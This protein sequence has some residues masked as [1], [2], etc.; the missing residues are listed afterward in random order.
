MELGEGLV[1]ISSKGI[2]S[3]PGSSMVNL[4]CGSME[5][6][7]TWSWLTWS[8]LV[9]MV[10]AEILELITYTT[11]GTGMLVKRGLTSNE[12]KVSSSG[13]IERC[14]IFL[15]K[16]VLSLTKDEVLP[17]KFWRILAMNFT[18]VSKIRTEKFIKLLESSASSALVWNSINNYSVQPW[19]YLSPLSMQIS[20]WEYFESLAIP[21]SPTLIKQWFRYV[22]DVH[23]ATRKDQVNQLQVHLNSI[24]PHIKFT[25][26]LPGTEG[27]PLLDILTKPSPNSIEYTVHRK[28]THT[29]RYLD[30][31]TNQ[32]ISAKLLSTASS[33]ELNKFVLHLNSLQRK[34]IT[35]TKSY[36]TTT[37]Q[38]SS[39]SKA[40][41]QQKANQT[42]PIHSKVYR[43]S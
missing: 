35:F 41:P 17:Q 8:F 31:N 23:S 14:S 5:L 26:E 10:Q 43:S 42:K 39:F 21:S 27:F 3:V 37:T 36:K 24:D 12:T 6:R 22:D 25:I 30:Y 15:M 11:T 32:P 9:K 40:K 1:R 19:I 33:T 20:T 38:H 28:P 18:N 34:W 2:P 7:Y 29:D 4:M 13:F 16:S